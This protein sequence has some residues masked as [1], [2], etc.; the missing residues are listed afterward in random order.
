MSTTFGVE[1]PSL[2][3][4][5]D[6]DIIPIA[7]RVGRKNGTEVFWTNPLAQLLPDY[8]DVIAMDNNPQGINT[9]E[10]LKYHTNT[11]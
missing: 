1:V 2:E 9:I 6:F 8:I 7:K 5:G 3:N 11:L 4:E 10:D